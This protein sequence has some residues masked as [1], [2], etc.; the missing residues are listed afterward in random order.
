MT[1]LREKK[2]LL[3]VA[4]LNAAGPSEVCVRTVRAPITLLWLCCGWLMCCG[5]A[6]VVLWLCCG[7]AWLYCGF[8][9]DGDDD[10]DDAV[11]VL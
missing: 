10:D 7:C 2:D 3:F 1:D 9:C 8:N 11:A 5:C 6:V 4:G